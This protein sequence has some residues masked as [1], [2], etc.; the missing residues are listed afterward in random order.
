M[1]SVAK[2]GK[3]FKALCIYVIVS[4][5]LTTGTPLPPA[6]AT[7][8]P[9]PAATEF[10]P[11]STTYS[12][13]VLKGLRL[14]PQNPLNIEFI[15]DTADRGKISQEEAAPLIKYFLAAL[16]IPEENIW[17]NLSPYEQDKIAPDSLGQTDL[18][19]D[20]L[21]QDYLLKQLL[22]SLTYPESQTGRDFWQETYKEVAQIAHTTNLPINTFNKIW[23]VP[24]K[25]EVYENGNM[26]L[27]TDASLKTMLE[28]DYLALQKAHRAEGIEHRANTADEINKVASDV[29]KQVILPKINRDVNS[30]KNFA[31]LRQIYHS[32]VLGIWF[33]K[34][35]KDSFY[36]HYINQGKTAGINLKDKDAKDKIYDLY[37][38]AFQKGIYNYIKTDNDL[39]SDKQIKRRYYSG[40]FSLNAGSSSLSGTG[41]GASISDAWL[42][43]KLNLPQRFSSAHESFL[44][45]AQ[46]LNLKLTALTSQQPTPVKKEPS[47]I[48]S[49]RE[50][51]TAWMERLTGRYQTA[52]SSLEEGNEEAASS[53]LAYIPATE[54]QS[55]KIHPR[56]SRSY[57]IAIC[58]TSQSTQ[59]LTRNLQLIRQ[60]IDEQNPNLQIAAVLG[61]KDESI[62]L[63]TEYARQL[64]SFLM[65]NS[66]YGTWKGHNVRAIEDKSR[67][68]LIIDRRYK[69]EVVREHDTNDSYPW[70][71]LN[72]DIVDANQGKP[73]NADETRGHITSGAAR[74]IVDGVVKKGT[75]GT[76]IDGTVSLGIN[77]KHIAE[78]QHV[79]AISD[80]ATHATQLA[81]EP[82]KQ[83]GLLAVGVAATEPLDETQPTLDR[84][85]LDNPEM[86]RA[87]SQNLVDISNQVGQTLPLVDESLLG[88][89]ASRS[90][91][92]PTP[93]GSINTIGVV[94]S[95]RVNEKQI[96][97]ALR[98]AS[99][100]VLKDVL[101]V[102]PVDVSRKLLR[103]RVAAI[104]APK[105]I[106]AIPLGEEG[107]LVKLQVWFEDKVGHINTLIRAMEEM[108]VAADENR[109]YQKTQW[110]GLDLEQVNAAV[111][112]TS[113]TKSVND[114]PAAKG[115]SNPRKDPVLTTPVRMAINGGGR[116]ALGLLRQLVGDPSI[117]LIAIAYHATDNFVDRL[118]DDSSYDPFYGDVVI[119]EDKDPETGY[120]YITINDK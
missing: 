21:S 24:E 88:K 47:L 6:Y 81:I 33:K 76:D 58:G 102:S 17:V 39:A 103:P 101:E 71:S 98:Q 27:I 14:D 82:L 109:Q 41:T 107:T 51:V 37:V 16:T 5:A 57:R 34:K 53:S 117:N 69:I 85:D 3:G 77:E 10:V 116:V 113:A 93:H 73:L 70:K 45:T 91:R 38:T 32:L 29:M 67:V 104:V 83:F 43:V 56:T 26:A 54:G 100:T 99:E 18:G 75:D 11:L 74:V 118:R 23:I 111:K 78:S 115:T 19:K 108:A 112:K 119:S 20:L 40:G 66:L 114:L 97:Q 65:N 95:Q 28:E 30:G 105:N 94:L 2:R 120:E 44:G 7:D 4:F 9:L 92:G 52:D 90:F 42:N 8:I 64:A 48:D 59:K 36:A 62:T 25:A 61:A 13:P 22:S 96:E 87:A 80:A 63:Q 15:I 1:K 49:M 106:K 72:I 89:A 110:S 86:Q 84:I 35:F 79:I 68:Y 31:T 50:Q 46:R 12:F 55:A 60:I